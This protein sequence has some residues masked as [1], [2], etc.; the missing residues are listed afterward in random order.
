MTIDRGSGFPPPPFVLAANHYSFLDPPLAGAVYGRR[1]RFVGL[2]DLFGRSRF[3]DWTLDVLEV[4]RV[5]RGTIPLS[6]MRQSLSHLA[7]GGVLGVFP[8]GTRVRRFGDAT[9]LP[10]AAWLAVRARVPLVAVAVTGTDRVLGVDN[11]LHRGRVTV[12][13]GPALHPTGDD[14]AA[15]DD[16]TQRWEDWIASVV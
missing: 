4:I 1:I 13:V 11:K 3:L 5:R 14:R 8:E 16:L 7:S 6:A 10:G 2:V 12:I 9:P 15:V